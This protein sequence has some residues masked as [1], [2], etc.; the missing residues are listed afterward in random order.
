[1]YISIY[2]E[3]NYNAYSTLKTITL[4]F[5]TRVIIYRLP[6]ISITGDKNLKESTTYTGRWT[7]IF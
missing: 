1:M 7:S 4:S 6:F 3:N 5:F 2:A